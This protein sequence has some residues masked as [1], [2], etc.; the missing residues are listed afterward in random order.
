MKYSIGLIP[1]HDISRKLSNV[2]REIDPEHAIKTIPHIT[3]KQPFNLL[4]GVSK[5]ILINRVDA[6]EIRF[7]PISIFLES[8]SRFYSPI[9]QNVIYL[10]VG[11]NRELM[12][13]QSD[14]VLSLSEIA[15]EHPQLQTQ[16]EIEVF[17]PHLTL[18]Q[19]LDDDVVEGV[20]ERCA[21][22]FEQIEFMAE[23][24]V[25]ASSDQEGNWKVIVKS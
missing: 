9:Y 24:L 5:Q 20:M 10:K 13:L 4:N 6:L 23:K 14:I 3:L 22:Q 1:P 19:G 21:S 2:R 12:T 16:R 18:A 7:I 8:L 11:M 25:V 17:Y 15:V